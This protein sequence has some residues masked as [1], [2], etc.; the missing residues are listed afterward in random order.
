MTKSERI[1]KDLV[2]VIQKLTKPATSSMDRWTD[3]WTA[4]NLLRE[5]GVESYDSVFALYLER[6]DSLDLPC[7]GREEIANDV[8]DSMKAWDQPR[9]ELDALN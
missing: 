6:G 7:E 1:A 3:Y 8:T 5:L 9:E 4:R 2:K